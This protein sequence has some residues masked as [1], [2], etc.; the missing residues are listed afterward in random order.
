MGRKLFT[1]L[2]WSLL[3]SITVWAVA[4]GACLLYDAAFPNTD[5]NERRAWNQ[6]ALLM[7]APWLGF[8][9]GVMYGVAR[10]RRTPSAGAVPTKGAA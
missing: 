7:L 10:A 4:F 1:I 6:F 2:G 3:G 8:V 5:T 9:G